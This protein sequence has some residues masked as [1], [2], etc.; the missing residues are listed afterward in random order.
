MPT[1][2]DPSLR[3]AAALAILVL[4]YAFIAVPKL[5]FTRI[6][7]PSGALLGAVLAVAL[8]VMTPE[9]VYREAI[10]F[11][12]LALLLGMMIL[13]AYLAEAAFFRS[14]SHLALRA[15]R[16]PRGLL[17]GVTLVC[18]ALSAFLVNDTSA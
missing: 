12:T 16:T 7:R 9:Q 8:G 2:L 14:A 18:A 5:P 1:L 4:T 11:D 10:N 6:D 15:A 3:P 13:A 17:I